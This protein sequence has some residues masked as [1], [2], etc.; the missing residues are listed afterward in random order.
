MGV[1]MGMVA[2]MTFTVELGEAP[3]MDAYANGVLHGRI[4]RAKATLEQIATFTNQM[5]RKKDDYTKG[6]V[7]GLNEKEPPHNG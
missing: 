1:T 4:A 3:N 5:K 2:P 7:A 6:F